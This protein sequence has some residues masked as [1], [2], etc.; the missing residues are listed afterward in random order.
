MAD[1]VTKRYG[2]A[3]AAR[4]SLKSRGGAGI[5]KRLTADETLKVRFLTEPD[6]WEEGYYHWLGTEFLWCNRKKACLGC[7]SGDKAKKVALANVLD[8][9]AGKVAI[10]Q[11][12]PS[13]ADPILKRHEKWGTI[14]DADCDLSR[15]G[16]GMND[17]RYLF[18]FDRP[19]RRN[20]DR[21]DLYD[22]SAVV[23]SDMGEDDEEEDEPRS[24]KRSSSVRKSSRRDEEEDEYED[25]EEDDD[26][27]EDEEEEEVPRRPVRTVARSKKKAAPARRSR[28]ADEDDDEEPEDDEEDDIDYELRK[29]QERRT[30][31]S[32]K[33]KSG[34]LD[35]FKPRTKNP[36]AR[37]VVRRSR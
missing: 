22:I 24:T 37:T 7:K 18:D 17:T 16:S 36:A 6:D 32:V 20:V 29:E 30:R 19:K 23:L 34:G 1:T 9:A 27:E 2:S 11:L 35:E 21:F 28:H 5:L 14:T 4:Q 31:S 26:E 25:E 15:E 13:L 3:R 10:M 33:K 12:S 8:I